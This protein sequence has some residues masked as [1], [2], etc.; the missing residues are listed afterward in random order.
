MWVARYL[1]PELL[2]TVAALVAAW[3]VYEATQSLAAAAIAGTLAETVGYY[4]V[5]VVRTVRG[6]AATNGPVAT[7]WLTIRS[8][9]AEFGPAEVV[10]TVLVRPLLLWAVPA[11]WG[12][13]PFAW[14]VGKLASDVVFYA[15]TI[16]SFE[17]GKR[18]IL[19]HQ[20]ENH[21]SRIPLDAAGTVGPLI[22]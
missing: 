17:L 6:H 3:G 12:A 16:T 1:V 18:I 7:S 11:A 9:G 19:P 20:K 2:G 10:D 8:L 14:L 4:S 5:I 21:D 13:S 15:I 22:R